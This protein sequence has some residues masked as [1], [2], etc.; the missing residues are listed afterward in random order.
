MLDLYVEDDVSADFFII[1]L[2]MNQL[3]IIVIYRDI[4][5]IITETFTE[6][7]KIKTL[8]CET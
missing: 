4:N 7:L 8:E 2:C 1:L 6:T 3:C 5:K